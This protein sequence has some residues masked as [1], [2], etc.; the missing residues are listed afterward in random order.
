VASVKHG[1]LTRSGECGSAQHSWC[2]VTARARRVL[3]APR[4]PTWGLVLGGCCW[5]EATG[6]EAAS[7][8]RLTVRH[9]L[10]VEV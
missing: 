10:Y 2:A 1:S 7:A 9:S 4:A 8:V 5:R 3:G 6:A